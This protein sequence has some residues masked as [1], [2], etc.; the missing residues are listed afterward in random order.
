VG[1]SGS[2]SPTGV[3]IE[4]GALGAGRSLGPEEGV[5]GCGQEN[6]ESRGVEV[7]C[8]GD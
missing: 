4:D 8:A 2:E 5:L 1:L 3:W 7:V 6:G